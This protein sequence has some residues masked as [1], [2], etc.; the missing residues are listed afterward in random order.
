MCRDRERDFTHEGDVGRLMDRLPRMDIRA[1]VDAALDSATLIETDDPRQPEIRFVR[2]DLDL[3]EE[4]HRR[5][6]ERT[7]LVLQ[8]RRD[9][10]LTACNGDASLFWKVRVAHFLGQRLQTLTART[11]V[12][13]DGGL[14]PLSERR[15]VSPP[16]AE[17]E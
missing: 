17:V 9:E 7:V 6:P 16:A 12:E 11:Y 15:T 13:G 8:E 10:L 4:A 14:T 2:A 3:L 1:R 5:H